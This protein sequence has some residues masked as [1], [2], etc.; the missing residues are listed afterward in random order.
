MNISCYY[1]YFKFLDHYVFFSTRK[2]PETIRGF[3]L[4]LFSLTLYFSTRK[5]YSFSRSLKTTSY[6]PCSSFDKSKIF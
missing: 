5:A 4:Q 6:S 1:K 3:F 2:A